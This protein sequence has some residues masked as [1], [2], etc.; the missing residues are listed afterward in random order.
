MP[1]AADVRT[2]ALV[3]D[4]A[5]VMSLVAL[6]VVPYVLRIGFYSDDWAFLSDLV[7]AG[8]RSVLGLTTY[9]MGINNNLALRPTQSLQNAIL[10]RLF[11]T[12]PLGYHLVNAA[13]LVAI[14]GVLVVLARRLGAPR[15][16]A[17]PFAV[18]ALVLPNAST[19]R[20]WFASFFYT[21]SLLLASASAL[22]ELASLRARGRR[23]VAWKAAALLLL[24][25]AGLGNEVVL[26]AL[27]VLPVGLWFLSRHRWEG[28][29]AAR[30]GR[31][32]TAAFLLGNY[33][34]LAAIVA[35][36]SRF[37]SKGILDPLALGKVTIR[38][39]LVDFGV[40]GLLAPLGGGWAAVRVDLL[41]AVVTVV[42][43]T[44]FVVHLWRLS[45]TG[46]GDRWLGARVW[47]RMIAGGLFLYAL[48]YG[49]FAVSARVDITTTGSANR[50]AAVAVLGVALVAVSLSGL[51]ATAI[52]RTR[53]VFTA[54]PTILVVSSLLT[55]SVLGQQWA[56]S[57]SLQQ[58]VLGA[59]AEER[60]ALPLDAAVI[61][62][63]VCPYEGAAV[64]FESYWDFAG[65][66]QLVYGRRDLRGDVLRDLRVGP[67]ALETRTYGVPVRYPYG[68]ELFVWDAEQRR[69]VPLPTRAA[70]VAVLGRDPGQP[71]C[72]PGGPGS[73]SL[74]RPGD[75]FDDAIIDPVERR[76]RG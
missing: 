4:V 59:I 26:P 38:A 39:P 48:G 24:V 65:G 63:G 30:F 36:K 42:V 29:L 9:Q 69:L 16:V 23:V 75:G 33:V 49:I 5:V 76:L 25:G 70:A 34:V 28:G 14:G 15:Y 50:A 64:V 8:E 18:L 73:G 22:A 57:W 32:G 20:F 60:P 31:S 7:V 74:Q 10:F 58:D 6:T 47:R 2:R 43:A 3:T 56:R 62:A 35:Y 12:D 66:L 61:L 44:A 19:N 11:G 1:N 40:H 72:A 27:S 45:P 53:A 21:L 17:F 68:D 46:P 37:E 51:A 41:G 54:V 71:G 67:D 13:M 52:G 55:V